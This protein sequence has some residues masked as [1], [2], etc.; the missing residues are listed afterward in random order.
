MKL[1]LAPMD[2]INDYPFRLLCEKTGADQT[3]TEM[4][5]AKAIFKNNKSMLTKAQKDEEEK[6]TALQ[7]FGTNEE[8]FKHA[9]DNLNNFNEYNL[10]LGC[11]IPSIIKQGAGY[12]L[13][14]RPSKIEKIIQAMVSKTNKPVSI[15]MRVG[16]DIKQTINIAK[17]A[18]LSGASK[19]ILHARSLSQRN[20]GEVNYDAV[21][22]LVE[23]LSIPVVGNGNIYDEKSLKRMKQTSCKEFMIGKTAIHNPN[24]FSLLKGKQPINCEQEYINICLKKEFDNIPKIKNHLLQMIRFKHDKEHYEKLKQEINSISSLNEL[25]K[26]VNLFE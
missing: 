10:N 12:V 18:E 8:H 2:Y 4:I 23:N 13:M 21:K 14:K 22:I 9:I 11:Y 6:N 24:I 17:T 19:I 20:E 26:I 5:N 16:K 15:K 1:L 25:K 7:L 3:Y